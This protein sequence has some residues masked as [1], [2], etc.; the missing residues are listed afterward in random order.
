M[1]KKTWSFLLLIVVILVGCVTNT[2]PEK[3]YKII[4]KTI[5][6]PIKD[7][8]FKPG[9]SWQWQL[10]G[11]INTKYDVDVYDIDLVETSQ[12]V[13]DELHENGKKVICYFSAGSWEEY[14]DDADEFPER[15]LG[16]TLEGWPDER[17]LDISKYKDF[18]GIMEARM[19]LAVKKSCGAIEPDN[20]D[21]Y[22]T[23]NGFRLRSDD[24]LEYNRWL[25]REAHERGLLIGLKNDLEQ[26]KE[27]VDHFDF[28]VNEQCFEYDECE[29]L[30][31]FIKQGKAVFGEEYELEPEEFCE[32]ANSMKFSFLKM[33]YELSGGRIGCDD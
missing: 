1:L 22:L 6:T 21:G 13:I 18:S 10:S 12:A 20:V 16:N 29:M 7:S 11:R 4:K 17:W 19:D 25:A 5:E 23:D 26:I 14:R 8:V 9:T 24:Q 27:L 33:E 30:K 31:P 15:V 2:I 3:E 32:K 28:A